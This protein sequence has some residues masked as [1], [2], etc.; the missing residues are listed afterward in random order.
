L[1]VAVRGKDR[2]WPAAGG[3]GQRVVDR[4]RQGE[5]GVRG[6]DG[7]EAAPLH[8]G[9]VFGPPD[10]AVVRVGPQE[11]LGEAQQRGIVRSGIDAAD[12]SSDAAG[13]VSKGRIAQMADQRLDL[14]AG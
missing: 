8:Q 13:A 10:G 11:V 3:V 9:A 1:A 7:G 2:R 4:G 6:E 12:I 5:G 14:R